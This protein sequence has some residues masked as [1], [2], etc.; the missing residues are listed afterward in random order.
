MSRA[1]FH[2]EKKGL[3]PDGN[4]DVSIVKMKSPART[5]S[6]NNLRMATGLMRIVSLLLFLHVT[7]LFIYL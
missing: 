2:D 7:L 3:S 4:H 5:F 1:L 6:H